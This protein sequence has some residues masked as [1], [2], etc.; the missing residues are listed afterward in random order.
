MKL[1]H[2]EILFLKILIWTIIILS[3]L[4]FWFGIKIGRF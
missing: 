4:H 2:F 3:N 1:T